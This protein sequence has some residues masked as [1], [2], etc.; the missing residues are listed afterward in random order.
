MRWTSTGHGRHE[1]RFLRG[2]V[3]QPDWDRQGASALPKVVV[4]PEYRA[5]GVGRRFCTS[6]ATSPTTGARKSSCSNGLRRRR[7]RQAHGKRRNRHQRAVGESFEL[8]W[9]LTRFAASAFRLEPLNSR[10]RHRT[11]IRIY[12]HIMLGRYIGPV[13][14]QMISRS[15][16]RR[17]CPRTG[18]ML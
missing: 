16:W 17:V 18:G 2:A 12:T 5:L 9:P 10:L 11:G 4:D 7:S 6:L 3:G 13:P 8:L 14:R 1:Q 15:G